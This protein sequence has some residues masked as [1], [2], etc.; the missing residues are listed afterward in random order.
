MHHGIRH[1]FRVNFYYCSI[2]F[3]FSSTT[4]AELPR[5]K[6]VCPRKKKGKGMQVLQRC[7]QKIQV[8]KIHS[9][10]QIEQ[11]L[12][13][14]STSW[15]WNSVDDADLTVLNR[16]RWRWTSGDNSSKFVLLTSFIA[17]KLCLMVINVSTPQSKANK[18]CSALQCSCQY[19]LSTA[20]DEKL[21]G[22]RHQILTL[23]LYCLDRSLQA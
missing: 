7:Y 20:L 16:I 22:Y 9:P 8:D 4:K 21:K 11:V 6:C 14:A 2:W 19:C 1:A 15:G 17:V 10:L 13:T 18:H 5:I 23:C 3:N 12:L